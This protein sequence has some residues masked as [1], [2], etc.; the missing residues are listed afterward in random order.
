MRD[1]LQSTEA[2]EIV[3][4]ALVLP[5]LLLIAVGIADFSGAFILRTKLVSAAREGAR[6]AASS[7]N[8]NP[9][10]AQGACE[11]VRN[12]LTNTGLLAIT[13]EDT[14]SSGPSAQACPGVSAISP[15]PSDPNSSYCFSKGGVT[16]E[17]QLVVSGTPH[18]C[19]RVTVL[20]PYAWK[21]NS[22]VALLGAK[23]NQ[24]ITLP[25]SFSSQT[26]MENLY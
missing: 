8:G 17:P 2:S 1:R 21:I 13:D 15:A 22:V 9:P 14:C 23:R 6:F 19:S 3:E 5:V 20:F 18:L 16:I 12:Y 4:F 25:T 10:T 24:S 7:E 11:M 26:V